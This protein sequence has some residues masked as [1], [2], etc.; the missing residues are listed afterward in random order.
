MA[1]VVQRP[2][3]VQCACGSLDHP[4]FAP[5]SVE[6]NCH[7]GGVR[8]NS[9][10]IGNPVEAIVARHRPI[11]APMHQDPASDRQRRRTRLGAVPLGVNPARL[12]P[13]VHSARP[14]HHLPV[15]RQALRP[16]KDK[17]RHAEGKIVT[18]AKEHLRIVERQPVA[19]R[20]RPVLHRQVRAQRH[21]VQ[22][23]VVHD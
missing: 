7:A 11:Q 17:I 16:R 22:R 5:V 3:E 6:R 14:K 1:R 13:I 4:A 10:F 18:P 9:A 19:H 20:Q 15:S 12:P 8:I 23:G 21:A 2:G